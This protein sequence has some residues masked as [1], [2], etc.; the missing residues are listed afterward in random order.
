MAIIAFPKAGRM[1]HEITIQERSTG[2]DSRGQISG[3]WTDT[4]TI[5]AEVRP[6]KGGKETELA[7]RKYA[8]AT[9][10]VVIHGI[11]TDDAVALGIST[12][13]LTPGSYQP[14][15]GTDAAELPTPRH[16]LKFRDMILHIGY[17]DNVNETD[18]KLELLCSRTQ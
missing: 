17:V 13:G 8:Q 12:D 10:V 5:P 9:Y 3:D 15:D 7:S 6:L 4:A 11:T 2:V 18:T 16:R 14:S 1:R